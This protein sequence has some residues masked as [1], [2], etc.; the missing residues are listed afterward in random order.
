MVVA[1]VATWVV[2]GP[3]HGW[4]PP[5]ADQGR[6]KA[7]VDVVPEGS[8]VSAWTTLA[9]HFTD[10]ELVYLFPNPWLEYDY[11]PHGPYGIDGSD[12]PDPEAVDWVFLRFDSYRTFDP[13]IDELMSSGDFEIAVDD[14][15]FVLLRRVP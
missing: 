12:V 6:I 14:P 9:P 1:A 15:P 11:G 8:S 3:A 10:R 7:I 4:A 5:S 13:V 2:A